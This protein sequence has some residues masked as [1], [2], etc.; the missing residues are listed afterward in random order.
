[1][2]Q[3]DVA[4]HAV[5]FD[6]HVRDD[7]GHEVEDVVESEGRIGENHAL[8]GR[9][10]NVSLVPK[11]HVFE[12]DDGVGTDN[13]GEAAN[14]LGE[15]RG[16]ACGGI[17]DDPLPDVSGPS[18]GFFDLA[19][20]SSLKRAN[21]GRDLVE[22]GGSESEHLEVLGVTIPLDDLIRHFG[23]LESE[24]GADVFFDFDGNAGEGANGT[25]EHANRYTFFHGDRAS[26]IPSHFGPPKG[27]FEAEGHRFCVDTVGSAHAEGVFEL[28]GPF[29]QSRHQSI[30]A[31]DEEG[32][33]V[34]HLHR[35]RGVFDVVGCE[36]VVDPS[37]F[38]AKARRNGTSEGDEVV[39]R[40][41]ELAVVFSTRKLRRA[42]FPHVVVIDDTELR[43]RFTGRDFDS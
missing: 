31:V 11:S 27:E 17:D 33:R 23:W 29:G 25:G 12:S 32:R 14:S 8:G 6:R 13:A 20:L 34:R 1:M 18:K 36:A 43:P 39:T 30:D 42:D 38:F 26:T 10:G 35:E 28:D 21:L 2:G 19:D 16:C 24:L 37:S 7:P 41:I 40:L 22:C 5:G 3:I 4:T 15:F 9:M